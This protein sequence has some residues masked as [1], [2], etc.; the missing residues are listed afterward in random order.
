MK[1]LILLLT[2]GL[3]ALA[4]AAAQAAVSKNSGPS[5]Q[6]RPT[7]IPAVPDN[8]G[9]PLRQPGEPDPLSIEVP[10][11]SA[12]NAQS[13][14]PVLP[15]SPVSQAGGLAAPAPSQSLSGV[16]WEAGSGGHNPVSASN[17]EAR[18]ATKSQGEGKDPDKSQTSAESRAEAESLRFDRAKARPQAP[19]LATGPVL[20]TRE[21]AESVQRLARVKGYGR[22]GEDHWAHLRSEILNLLAGGRSTAVLAKRGAA[23]GAGIWKFKWGTSFRIFFHVDRANGQVIFLEARSKEEL[24][25]EGEDAFYEE[26]ARRARS[27]EKSLL[28]GQGEEGLFRR[29]RLPLR[30]KL[31]LRS[32]SSI[33]GIAKIV[34]TAPKLIRPIDEYRITTYTVDAPLREVRI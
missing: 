24:V 31:S 34:Y 3:C 12:P 23:R 28:V 14:P 10:G 32:C 7:P 20:F 2:A 29:L 13:G 30:L 25:A 19:L 1:R 26:L 15:A 11:V 22:W 5:G 9:M 33:H 27:L 18:E 8:S 4:P 6:N 17:P 21:F 16:S